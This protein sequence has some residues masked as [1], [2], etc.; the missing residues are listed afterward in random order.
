MALNRHSVSL[1]AM[2][3]ALALAGCADDPEPEEPPCAEG[4]TYNPETEECEA[5][6]PTVTCPSGEFYQDGLCH[7][8][9]CVI[10]GTSQTPINLCFDSAKAFCRVGYA[11]VTPEDWTTPET[12]SRAYSGV[13]FLKIDPSISDLM[14]QQSYCAQFCTSPELLAGQFG[15]SQALAATPGVLYTMECSVV[16][17]TNMPFLPIA[18]N[19]PRVE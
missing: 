5:P 7:P 2:A 14:A 3:A 9:Q 19:D 12:E 1:L 11:I 13:E 18:S 15:V 8:V 6:P 4:E 16:Q 10:A 17:R